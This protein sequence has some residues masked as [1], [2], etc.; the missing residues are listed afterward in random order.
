[1]KNIFV[2]LLFITLTYAFNGGG[3][4]LSS[5]LVL[6]SGN[7]KK[8]KRIRGEHIM[9]CAYNICNR[10]VEDRILVTTGFDH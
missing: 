3:K 8:K 10:Y 5:G 1:M 9:Q 2:T 4:P 7:K 6:R